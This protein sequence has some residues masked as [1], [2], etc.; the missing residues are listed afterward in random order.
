MLG[1]ADLDGANLR[2]ADISGTSMLKYEREQLRGRGAVGLDKVN[3]TNE[4]SEE[5]TLTTEATPTLHNS[6]KLKVAEST[7]TLYIRI[8]QQP[9][10]ARNLATTTSAL[11][12]LHTQ[13]A[14]RDR[15]IR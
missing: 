15:P 13:W 8:T 3:V 9:L 5:E 10:T 1:N 12:Q 14:Y 2:G 6:R 4:P 11:T 7:S